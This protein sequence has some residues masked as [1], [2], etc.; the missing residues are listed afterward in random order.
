MGGQLGYPQM[1]SFSLPGP[2]YYDP[3]GMINPAACV[4]PIQGPAPENRDTEPSKHI[5][6]KGIKK[7]FG[8][9]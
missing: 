8:C 9:C 1:E 4:S 7:W 6:R 5:R 3:Y 2:A